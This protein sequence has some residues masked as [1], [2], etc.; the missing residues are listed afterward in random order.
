VK[1]LPLGTRSDHGGKGANRWSGV[2]VPTGTCTMAL[3][4]MFRAIAETSAAVTAR[5][6]SS[7]SS[8]DRIG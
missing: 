8:I 4:N 1:V 6:S 3:S 5:R 2:P 7:A